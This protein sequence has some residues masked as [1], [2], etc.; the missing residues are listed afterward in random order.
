[1]NRGE[2]IGYIHHPQ[3]LGQGIKNDFCTLADRYPYCSSIQILYSFLLHLTN[4]HEVN[5]QLKKAAAYT[6]SRRKLKELLEDSSSREYSSPKLP[7]PLTSTPPVVYS[8]EPISIPIKDE[9][10]ERVRRRLAEIEAEK[11][12]DLKSE[13]PDKVTESLEESEDSM[14]DLL[15]KKEI[16]EKFIREEPR[17]LPSKTSFFRPSEFAVKSNTDDTDIV[18][19]TLATIYLEQGNIAKARMVY[20]KLSLLFPEKSSYF[21]AQIEKIGD[22]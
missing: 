18:S 20:E 5:F 8:N 4:D 21:A 19:E 13:N 3:T 22:K 1:M 14:M 2:F 16:I 17:I 15:S 7:P 6:S 9:L 12:Q 10:M 11:N